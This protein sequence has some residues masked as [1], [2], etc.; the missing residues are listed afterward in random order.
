VGDEGAVQRGHGY[1][2]GSMAPWGSYYAEVI[3]ACAVEVTVRRPDWE[4]IDRAGFPVPRTAG[5]GEDDMIECI[6]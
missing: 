6:L 2:A 5:F 3:K 1:T 4:L